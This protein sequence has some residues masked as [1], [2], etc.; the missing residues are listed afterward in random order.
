MSEPQAKIRR[1]VRLIKP[2]LQL[3]LCLVFLCVAV[4]CILVQFTLWS[5]TLTE[6]SARDT[7]AASFLA[8]ALWRHLGITVALLIPLTLLMVIK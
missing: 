3:K 5:G 2:T 6:I 7:K 1:R 8:P 4:A